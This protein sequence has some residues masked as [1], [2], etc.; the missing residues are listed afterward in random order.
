MTEHLLATFGLYGAML[1]YCFIA[2]LIPFLNTEIVLL[3]LSAWGAS[4]A[5]VPWLVLL[6]VIGQ[7]SANV[8]V[9]YAGVGAFQLPKGRMK[10]RIEK[11]KDRLERWQNRPYAVLVTSSTVG[12]PPLYLVSFAAGGL[13]M[14]F[15]AFCAIGFAGRLLR[16]GLFA[17][18][19]WLR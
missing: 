14:N 3:G 7:M 5:Q 16:F 12:L 19:P 18:I 10:A 1:A 17:A 8:I 2:G 4:A 15:R 6:A 13:R 9:Y 11:A